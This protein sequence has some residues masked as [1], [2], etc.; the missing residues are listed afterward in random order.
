MVYHH[1]LTK[2]AIKCGIPPKDVVLAGYILQEEF[3]E[4]E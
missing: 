4:K 3:D 2:V 1:F